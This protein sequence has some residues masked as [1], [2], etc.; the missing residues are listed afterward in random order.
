E[1]YDV[2]EKVIPG[3]YACGEVIGGVHG[4]ESMPSCMVGWAITSGR[5]SGLVVAEALGK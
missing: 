3:L 4:D 1:V 2:D 5:M